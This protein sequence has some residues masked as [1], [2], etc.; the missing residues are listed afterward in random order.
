M[1]PTTLRFIIA[2]V[3]LIHG[4]GHTM[5]IFPAM[6]ASPSE[7]WN[8]HSWLLSGLIGDTLSRVLCVA[9]YL[10]AFVGF[11][12]AALALLGW[13]V[14][15]EWWRT[16]A[17]VSSVISLLALA[18]FLNALAAFFNKLGAIAVDVAVLVALLVLNWP[19]E[20]DIGY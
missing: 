9:L 6:G 16:L 13:V 17:I 2:A 10:A 11:V 15:H 12:G 14:P 7:G 18:L 3:L 8:T 4:I 19:T 5:A 20:A 1:S